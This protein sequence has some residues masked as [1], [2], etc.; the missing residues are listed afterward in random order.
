MIGDQKD[1]FE[2][3]KENI[4]EESVS[5]SIKGRFTKENIYYLVHEQITQM[6][7]IYASQGF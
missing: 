6:G 1:R 2:K 4:I 5:L 3:W 7:E